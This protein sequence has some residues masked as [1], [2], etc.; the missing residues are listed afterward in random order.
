M[1]ETMLEDILLNRFNMS[2]WQSGFVDHFADMSASVKTNTLM[3]ERLSPRGLVDKRDP[4]TEILCHIGISI[5]PL[6]DHYTP[7]YVTNTDMLPWVIKQEGQVV[8]GADNR[9]KTK[10]TL[11]SPTRNVLVWKIDFEKQTGDFAEIEIRLSGK[12][13]SPEKS[14]EL[15]AKDDALF[16]YYKTGHEQNG[17]RS[18]NDK[19]LPVWTIRTSSE[20]KI[21]IDEGL[22]EYLI[23]SGPMACD[24]GGKLSFSIQIDYGL[25]DEDRP[26]N[27]KPGG[28][29]FNTDSNRILDDRRN[30]WAENIGEINLGNGDAAKVVRSAAGLIRT[31]IEWPK[32]DGSSTIASYCSI[33]NWCSTAFFWDSLV[34]SVGLS[35]FNPSLARDAVSALYVMQ[36]QDGCV[37]THSYAHTAGSTFYPQAPLTGWAL[38]HMEQ[39]KSLSPEFLKDILPKTKKLFSWF[40]NTQD[41]DGDGLPEWRFTGSTADNSPLYDRYA[42]HIRNYTDGLWNIYLPPVASVSLASYLITEAKSLAKLYD[43]IG[44]TDEKDFF[45]QEAKRLEQLLSKIC[46]FNDEMFFDY[47]H[48]NSS[49]NKV[50]TLYSFLPI[51]AGVE[52]DEAVKK[53]MIENYLLN[54][55]HFF[56]EYP[57]PYLA[58]SEK[59]YKPDGYWRGRVW[60]HTTLWMLELLWD[61]GYETEADLGA[62][63]LLRMM[64][65]KEEIL[66]NYNSARSVK[67]GGAPDY[68]WSLAS[69]IY[70]QNRAYRRPSLG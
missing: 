37:P 49:F 26:H 67:G 34:A 70:L 45:L 60:P 47:D 54:E 28:L 10:A 32:E 36:R 9:L 13:S 17:Y 16:A 5:H 11:Y 61:N 24:Q 15:S 40:I 44:Q 27:W 3:L 52:M 46:L 14:H 19:I 50:L 1:N 12:L 7:V 18:E 48:H 33:T 38:L 4:L 8:Q 41:H 65:Q 62:D 53:N 25:A 68:N 58:Y 30:W 23:D 64:S 2:N 22:S 55:A 35:F 39:N 69:Y 57:F 42:S 63:R 51:W 21:S 43:G 59:Q 6:S 20:T 29:C 56:G 31:G 66:E